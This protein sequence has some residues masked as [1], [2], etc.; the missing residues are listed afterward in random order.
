MYHLSQ[1]AIINS[2]LL[3][4]LYEI[5]NVDQISDHLFCLN[6]YL[7]CIHIV[8]HKGIPVSKTTTN[9]FTNKVEYHNAEM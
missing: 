4:K 6:I 1:H 9:A 8:F 7:F 5:Y 2:H 3:W